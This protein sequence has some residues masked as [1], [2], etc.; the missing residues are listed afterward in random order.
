MVNLMAEVKNIQLIYFINGYAT[1]PTIDRL[2]DIDKLGSCNKYLIKRKNSF[3]GIGQK[4]L[5]KEELVY[6]FNDDYIIQEYINFQSEVQFYYVKD[7]FEYALEFKPSKVP[8]YPEPIPYYNTDAELELAN[9]FA[10]LNGNYYGIQRIDFIKLFDGTLLL[11]EIE[12]IAPYLDLDC[13]AEKTKEQF[14]NDYKNMVYEYM[15]LYK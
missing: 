4:I 7:K 1:I 10:K 13:V 5:N 9:T 12:D 14:V 11:T 8:V 3:D 6:M 2:R 15:N